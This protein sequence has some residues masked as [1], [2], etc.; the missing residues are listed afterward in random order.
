MEK[1]VGGAI[2][3]VGWGSLGGRE[4]WGKKQTR[5]MQSAFS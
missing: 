4:E 1:G 3:L 2:S 5:G